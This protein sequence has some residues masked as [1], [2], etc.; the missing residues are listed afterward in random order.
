[1]TV[2]VDDYKSKMENTANENNNEADQHINS[3]YS[4]TN[5]ML[6]F[7]KLLNDDNKDLLQLRSEAW[8]GI[9]NKHR[10]TVWKILL[11]YMPPTSSIKNNQILE[12]KRLE[13]LN[14]IDKFYGNNND[15]KKTTL[16][17]PDL[18]QIIV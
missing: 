3:N 18:K 10:A 16:D 12:R 9:T 4:Y 14:S 1:M 6:K 11:G 15:K 5:K 17:S 7:E 8:T 2:S 13:Y